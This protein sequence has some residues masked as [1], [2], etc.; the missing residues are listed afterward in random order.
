MEFGEEITDICAFQGVSSLCSFALKSGKIGVYDMERYTNV[1]EFDN[2][3]PIIR[4]ETD[5]EKNIYFADSKMVYRHD[6]RTPQRPQPMFRSN[7]DILSFSKNEVN[8]E[9]P[10]EV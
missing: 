8:Q 5:D 9:N 2:R 1:Y 6:I 10:F 4:L 3:F 7:S